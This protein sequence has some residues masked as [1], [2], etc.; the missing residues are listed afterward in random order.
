MGRWN[1]LQM[2]HRWMPTWAY[3][4]VGGGMWWTCFLWTQGNG[5]IIPLYPVPWHKGIDLGCMEEC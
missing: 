5:T 4:R 1:R 2:K 3:I